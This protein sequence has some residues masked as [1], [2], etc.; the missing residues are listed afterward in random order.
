MNPHRCRRVL[1]V[2]RR[3]I[4]GQRRLR[5]MHGDPVELLADQALLGGCRA[6]RRVPDAEENDADACY[7]IILNVGKDTGTDDG[8]VAAPPR[9]FVERPAMRRANDRHM[10]RR[11]QFTRLDRGLK[12]IDEVIVRRHAACAVAADD[13]QFGAHRQRHRRKFRRRIGQ[14]D[15]A[16]ERSLVADRPMRDV[17]RGVVK[18]RR[19]LRDQRI[20][21]RFAMARQRADA[22]PVAVARDAAQL[23]NVG[24][25]D[26]GLRRLQTQRK[27][28]H[29]ALA[30]RDVARVLASGLKQIQRLRDGRRPRVAECPRLQEHISRCSNQIC[31]HLVLNLEHAQTKPSTT[32]DRLV[33]NSGCGKT[34]HH[35]ESNPRGAGLDEETCQSRRETPPAQHARAGARALHCR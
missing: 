32:K 8:V 2:R 27:G 13:F 31:D 6:H 5:G 28:R 18:Q 10:N 19:M 23:C 16:A 9:Q 4:I 7:P 14:R 24:D 30:A 11:Q 20:G 12:Q 15:A 17:R 35:P 29:Q 33:T 3:E 22:Q 1:V 25:V 26:E 21:Q 34:A